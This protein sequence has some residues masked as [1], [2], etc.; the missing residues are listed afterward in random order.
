VYVEKEIKRFS[1]KILNI[2][3]TKLLNGSIYQYLQYREKPPN[4][5]Y[6][7]VGAIK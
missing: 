7:K 1:S 2:F 6:I 3:N 5:L 4:G